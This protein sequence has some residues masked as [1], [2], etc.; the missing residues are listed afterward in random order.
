MATKSKKWGLKR[1]VMVSKPVEKPELSYSRVVIH[2]LEGK[3]LLASDI[4]TGKS[5]PQCFC[6]VGPIDEQPDWS[7]DNPKVFR[8]KVCNTTIDPFFN[9][10]VIVPVDISDANKLLNMRCIVSL[11]DEDLN[12]GEATTYDDMGMVEIPLI[13]ILK[14]GKLI[15]NAIVLPARVYTLQKSPGMRKVDGTIKLTFSLIIQKEDLAS[16]DMAADE[17]VD[18]ENMDAKPIAKDNKFAVEEYIDTL[19]Q[20]SKEKEKDFNLSQFTSGGSTRMNTTIKS[21]TLSPTNV[22]RR[23]KTYEGSNTSN[24]APK[25]ESNNSSSK[26]PSM[27][28]AF[29]RNNDSSN[30]RNSWELDTPAMPDEEGDDDIEKIILKS[31]LEGKENNET[32]KKA[33]MKM[34]EEIEQLKSKLDNKETPKAEQT[35]IKAEER[36]PA[37]VPVEAPSAQP[38]SSED[39]EDL[40]ILPPSGGDMAVNDF[41]DF[42]EPTKKKKEEKVVEASS[43]SVANPYPNPKPSPAPEEGGVSDLNSVSSAKSIKKQNSTSSNNSVKSSSRDKSTPNKNNDSNNSNSSEPRSNEKEPDSDSNLNMSQIEGL[44]SPGAITGS[45]ATAAKALREMARQREEMGRLMEDLTK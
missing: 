26:F 27:K 38:Q 18:E 20:L 24:A 10:D 5:D 6:W 25:Q 29:K 19:K 42:P 32:L 40:L 11:K 8:S 43:E 2:I 3:N 37:E 15:K 14:F 36:S 41:E 39:D 4:E 45:A 44:G 35:E 12:T 7:P 34:M 23:Q 1:N 31:N 21:G 13:S 22:Q 33:M 30:V 16:S 9:E 17:N 28:E